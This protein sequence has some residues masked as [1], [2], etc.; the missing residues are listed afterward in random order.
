LVATVSTI[1]E[2]RERASAG[3][4]L[5]ADGDGWYGDFDRPRV[6]VTPIAAPSAL[7]LAGFSAATAMVA[8]VQAG[9]L[10]ST[11]DW[12][13]IGLFAMF[14]GG[15]AQ[16]MAGMWSYRA[17]DAIA[18]VAHG[19]WGA[20]WM[21]FGVLSILILTHVV[22]APVPGAANDALGFWF[23]GL[24]YVTGIA[25]L[26]ATFDNLV[27][28]VVLWTLAAG[29]G[30]TSAGWFVDG[31]GGSWLHVGGWLFVISAALAAYAVTAMLLAAATGRTILPLG[32][33]KKAANIPGKKP[34]GAIEIP[35]GEPGVKMGQ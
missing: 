5:A 19:T 31:V 4:A 30:F 17:R 21:A 33:F 23:L 28:A 6:V 26:A 15:L 3:V 1:D 32:H 10:G 34:V 7:G 27:I 9:W 14:F 22:A 18:T 24:A 25:A 11:A 8:I 16:F 35:W 20:F 29:S 2:R 12:P 13:V